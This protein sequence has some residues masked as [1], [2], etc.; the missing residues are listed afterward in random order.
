MNET[1]WDDL[2]GSPSAVPSPE[3]NLNG[4]IFN[5]VRVLRRSMRTN[6]T[7]CQ[8]TLLTKLIMRAVKP[9][10]PPPTAEGVSKYF[11]QMGLSKSANISL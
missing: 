6:I 9:Y 4:Q 8:Y 1:A 11:A 7:M 5:S 3:V 2:R 10:F